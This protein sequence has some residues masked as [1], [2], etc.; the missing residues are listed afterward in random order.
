MT[1]KTTEENVK[2]EQAKANGMENLLNAY[3]ASLQH[4]IDFWAKFKVANSTDNKE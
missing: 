2:P 4:Q 3:T 1:E